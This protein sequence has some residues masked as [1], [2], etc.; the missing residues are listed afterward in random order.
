[1]RPRIVVETQAAART[2]RFDGKVGV[3][4]RDDAVL[5]GGAPKKNGR[6]EKMG[7]I[8]LKIGAT[9]KIELGKERAFDGK[10]SHTFRLSELPRCFG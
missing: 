1:M 10:A 8:D 2:R 3:R 5:D 4:A 7:K 9:G 6:A